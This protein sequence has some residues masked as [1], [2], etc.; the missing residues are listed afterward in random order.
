FSSQK[1]PKPGE[2]DIALSL[3]HPLLVETLEQGVNLQGETFLVMEF[4]EGPMLRDLI[5][6]KSPLLEGKR[7]PLTISTAEAIRVVH[8]A[9][10]YHRD[11]C[12]HNFIVA[13]DGES[14]K[15]IDFGLSIPATE[16]FRKPGNRTGKADYMAPELIRRMPT[17]HRV[18]IFAWAVTMFEL[19]TGELPWVG[20]SG[21]QAAQRAAFKPPE[22]R[23]I[24]PQVHPRL[25]SVIDSCL[26]SNPD[27]RHGTMEEIL[28]RLRQAERELDSPA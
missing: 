2:G 8:E 1:I 15:L 3:K 26:Q 19:W 25:A 17:D 23:S 21:M 18:D 16:D 14:V 9:G 22:I 7:M 20:G 13:P 24:A 10:F 28:I 4:V 5:I 12:P 11:L 27:H 6:E